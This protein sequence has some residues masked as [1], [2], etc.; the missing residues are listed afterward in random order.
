MM[1]NVRIPKTNSQSPCKMMVGR[2]PFPSGFWPLFRSGLISGISETRFLHPF[3]CFLIICSD[4]FCARWGDGLFLPSI[5]KIIGSNST[6]DKHIFVWKEMKWKWYDMISYDF[7]SFSSRIQTVFLSLVISTGRHSRPWW[8]CRRSGRPTPPTWYVNERNTSHH[9]WN[10]RWTYVQH[11][12]YTII[13]VELI[14]V[15]SIWFY[16]CKT[17]MNCK[18]K[19]QVSKSTCL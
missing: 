12:Y 14:Y 9:Y 18:K 15:H 6:K 3:V 16:M 17:N 8:A 5:S 10:M 13:D 7:C 4:L 2:R 1:L 19:Q 11:I